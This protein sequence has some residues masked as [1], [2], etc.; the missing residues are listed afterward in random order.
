MIL[1][2]PEEP[3]KKYAMAFTFMVHAGL[4]LALFLGVQWKRSTPEVMDVELWSSKPTP[5]TY[6]PPPPPKPE[7][8]VKPEPKPIPKVEPKPEPL[9]PKKPDIVV[10]EEKKPP[11]PDDKKSVQPKPEIKP[12]ESKPQVKPPPVDPFKEMM[13][14][15]ERQRKAAELKAKL[16]AEADKD[17]RASAANRG[18]QAWGDKVSRHVRQYVVLPVN[19]QG[20]PQAIFEL[21]V[22]PSGDVLQPIK[23]KKSS[24]NSALDTAAE[25]AIIKASPLPKPESGVFPNPLE[26]KYKPFEE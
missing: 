22:L 19:I 20:N 13:E 3:G 16:G 23:L 12:P 17:Q 4:I 26:I 7:P 18:M 10:K 11:K 6:V 1:E 5:A 24:G 14:R 21:R 8:E 25:R 2:R 15:D 9:P